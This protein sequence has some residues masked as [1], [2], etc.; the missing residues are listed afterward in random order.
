MT[1][2]YVTH[3]NRLTSREKR[4]FEDERAILLRRSV[5]WH[6]EKFYEICHRFIACYYQIY[7]SETKKTRAQISFKKSFSASSVL[8]FLGGQHSVGIARL[9]FK[10][11]KLIFGD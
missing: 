1:C 4:F 10:Q 6:F 8:T 7:D 9:V 3:T 2:I 5:A 11:I